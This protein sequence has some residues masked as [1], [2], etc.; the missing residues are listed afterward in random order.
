MNRKRVRELE[1]DLSSLGTHVEKE[2][3][4]WTKERSELEQHIQSQQSRIDVGSMAPR[5]KPAQRCCI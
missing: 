4:E 1:Y 3:L 2:R 5:I